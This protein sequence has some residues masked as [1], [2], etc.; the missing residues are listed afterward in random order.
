M[1][2]FK[3][4][5]GREW[6]IAVNV[7]SAKRVRDVIGVDLF[8]LF[9]D[10]CER[11]LSDPCLLVDLLYVLCE[12]QAKETVISDVQFGEGMVGDCIDAAANA[13]LEAVAD[14][15]PQAKR[16]TLRKLL[17]KSQ[18]IAAKMLTAADQALDQIDADP[19]LLNSATNSPG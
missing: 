2:Q 9:S 19:A 7:G 10:E 11:V 17:T 4:S 5:V 16:M 18:G 3:D 15:F 1:K 6:S 12:Q 14:F 8:K 13:L